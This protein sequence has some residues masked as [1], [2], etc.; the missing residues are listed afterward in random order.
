MYAHSCRTVQ[1]YPAVEDMDINAIN[2][3]VSLKCHEVRIRIDCCVLVSIE[4]QKMEEGL[5]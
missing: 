1:L 3:G 5:V 4:D 2:H